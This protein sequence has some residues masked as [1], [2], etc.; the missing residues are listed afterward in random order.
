MQIES[1]KEKKKQ[2]I[3]Y[4]TKGYNKKIIIVSVNFSG[5]LRRKNIIY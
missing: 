1:K 2:N 5:V 3:F 4:K